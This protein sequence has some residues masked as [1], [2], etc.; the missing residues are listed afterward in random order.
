[1]TGAQGGF[2]SITVVTGTAA[3]SPG[4]GAGATESVTAA[5]TSGKT[6]ISGGAQAS[7]DG[8]GTAALLASFPSTTGVNGIW[9]GTAVAITNLTSPGKLDITVWAFC[10]P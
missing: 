2:S 4:E 3:S 7:V 8:G 10:G 5:C 9:T 6:L 1:V